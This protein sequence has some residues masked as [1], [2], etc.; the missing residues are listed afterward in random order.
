MLLPQLDLSVNSLCG[1]DW[2][3]GDGTYTAEGIEAIA[4]AISRSVSLQQVAG[5]RQIHKCERNITSFRSV[6]RRFLSRRTTLVVT[7]QENLG[8]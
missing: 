8:S 5:P 3:T 7:R 2:E 1:I 6:L 4:K